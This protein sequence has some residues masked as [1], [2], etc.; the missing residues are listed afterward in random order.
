MTTF[1]SLGLPT[2]GQRVHNGLQ[3]L[4]GIADRLRALRI[5]HAASVQQIRDAVS[6]DPNLTAEGRQNMLRERTTAAGESSLAEL[7]ALKDEMTRAQD[8]IDSAI[9][10][11]WPNGPAGLDILARCA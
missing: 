1:P 7:G 10:G 2:P 3:T 5:R 9:A 8:A 6:R 11:S 4:N